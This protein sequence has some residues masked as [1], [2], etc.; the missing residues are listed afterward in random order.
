[1]KDLSLVILFLIG[2]TASAVGQDIPYLSGRVND[3]AGIL[4]SQ[5]IY[6]LENQ[7]K[8][9]EQKTSNQVVVLT[10]ANLDDQSIEDFSIK[11]AETWKLGQKEKDNGVLLLIS[12]DDHKLRIEVG[13]GLEGTLTDALC[14][15]IIRHQIVPRFKGGDFDGGVKAGVEAILGTID[16]T[17]VAETS[18][19]EGSEGGFVELGDKLIALAIFGFVVGLFTIIALIQK[20]G[21]SWFLYV[22]LIPF[23]LAFPWAILGTFIPAIV[24]IVGFPL[25]KLLLRNN[26]SF[27]KWGTAWIASS[28]S[29]GW[30]SG[31]WSSGGGGFSSGGFS[32]G[33][34]SFSGGGSSG[35]W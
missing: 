32:G 15:Q 18:D 2:A 3:Y 1:M 6:D 23:W 25:L 28:S 5:T 34:G 33:G 27:Q 21:A 26:K 35:G 7:L 11:V 31:G 20:G 8:A 24:Y 19:D 30:S 9:H 17:Y 4:S 14:S 16:G 29:R 12:R 22:F 10:V 13:R